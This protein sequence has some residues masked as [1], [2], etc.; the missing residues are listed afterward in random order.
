MFFL[1]VM[2]DGSVRQVTKQLNVPGVIARM[3]Y[4]D[5]TARINDTT[6][7]LT[8]LEQ[9]IWKQLAMATQ[10]GPDKPAFKT[11]GLATR[12]LDNSVDVRNVVLR[13]TDALQRVLWFHTDVRASKVLQ[14]E[15]FPEARLL[16]WDEGQQLQ[17]RVKVITMIHINDEAADE[18][19]AKLGLSSRKMYLSA[20]KP[21]SE[22]LRPYPGFP[23]ALGENLPSQADS[24][25]GRINFAAVEC[26]VL[27]LDC[28][29]LSRAGQTR[30]HFIFE[31]EPEAAW[32]A[33]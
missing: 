10:P 5:T 20:Y 31:P 4:S 29:H 6:Y 22:Q 13:Q 8:T 19:W 24:E 23:E 27:E 12:T 11:C 7:T 33:P 28:L 9:T 21:G 15:G 1:E 26:R 32:L 16:F 3:H 2:P 25:A 30:A 14:L 18:Q 17:L